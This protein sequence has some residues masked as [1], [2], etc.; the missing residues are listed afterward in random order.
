MSVRHTNA[1][2]NRDQQCKCLGYKSTNGWF[3]GHSYLLDINGLAAPEPRRRPRY[4][5]GSSFGFSQ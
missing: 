2:R 4:N 1:G 3:S 5:F